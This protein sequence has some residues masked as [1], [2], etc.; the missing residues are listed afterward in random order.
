[1]HLR[2]FS[3]V[4]EDRFYP[5]T[6]TRP[7]EELRIG[8]LTI[9]E[10]WIAQ[11]GASSCSHHHPFVS[12]LEE[13][14]EIP[15]PDDD[16]IYW[17][18]SAYFPDEELDVNKLEPNQGYFD[19]TRPVLVALEKKNTLNHE[20]DRIPD[21]YACERILLKKPLINIQHI[22]DILILNSQEILRDIDRLGPKPIQ[23]QQYPLVNFS[24]P[25]HIYAE[26]GAFIEPGAILIAHDGPI[27]LGKN[28]T[29]EAGAILKGSVAVGHSAT[30]KMGARIY[31]GSTIGPHCKV[32]GEVSNSVFHSYSNKAHDGFVGNSVFGQWCN[33][34]ADTNTSNLKNNYSQVRLHDWATGEERETGLQFLGTVMGDHSKT[35]INTMLNTGTVCGVCSN[36]FVSGFPPKFIPSF[37]WMGDSGYAVYRF[38]K[39]VEAMKAMMA[40]RGIE[41]P[42]QYIAMMKDIF[43]ARKEIQ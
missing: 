17:V 21:F 29:I 28:S 35:A 13:E 25:E 19:N 40:R 9:T 2:F 5:L 38:E 42:D 20:H 22:W 11:L 27:Y 14:H 26:P 23:T 16:L 12:C 34:G 8:I 33:L 43:R 7:V 39:A 10:K 18:N 32:G 30:V 4:K 36:I 3:D 15:N 1:M 24:R 31:G 41:P 37:S 6:L